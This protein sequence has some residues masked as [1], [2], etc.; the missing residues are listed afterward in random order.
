[1][2]VWPLECCSE[3]GLILQLCPFTALSTAGVDTHTLLLL[4]VKLETSFSSNGLQSRAPLAG[5]WHSRSQEKGVHFLDSQPVQPQD[6]LQ[7]REVQAVLPSPSWGGA[8][9]GLH[10]LKI[11]ALSHLLSNSDGYFQS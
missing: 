8:E 2:V 9:R 4:I 5:G 6:C 7:C 1:M 3:R 10:V 11:R